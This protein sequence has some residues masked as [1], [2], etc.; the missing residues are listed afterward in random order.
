MEHQK[1]RILDEIIRVARTLSVSDKDIGLLEAAKKQRQFSTAVQ[2]VKDAIPQALLLNGHNPL[3]LLYSALSEGLHAQDDQDD[4]ECLEA[5]HDIRI[6][7]AELA[8]SL[9]QALKNKA[10]INTAI[11]RFVRKKNKG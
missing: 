7:L 4:Q 3:T 9:E 5:A 1:N 2:S 6:V 8:D 11:A 10:E